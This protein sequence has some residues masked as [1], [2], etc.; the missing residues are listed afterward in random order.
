M[1]SIPEILWNLSLLLFCGKRDFSD[2]TGLRIL[3]MVILDFLGR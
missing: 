1:D 2:I 3:T